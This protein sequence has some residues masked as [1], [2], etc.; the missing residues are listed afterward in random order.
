MAGAWPATGRR[1]GP[2]DRTEE[3]EGL[4]KGR[5]NPVRASGRGA[6]SGD[7]FRLGARRQQI[8]DRTPQDAGEVGQM[9]DRDRAFAPFDAAHLRLLELCAGG[10]VALE[11]AALGSDQHDLPAHLGG[12][13]FF[14]LRLGTHGAPM[15][16]KRTSMAIFN[17]L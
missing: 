9:L 16:E 14:G 1:I 12:K 8:D 15:N 11:H 7:R 3:E 17:Q 13:G 6:P 4:S 5:R 10:Q 2:R